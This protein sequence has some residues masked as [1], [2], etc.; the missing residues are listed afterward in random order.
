VNKPAIDLSDMIDL[1]HERGLSIG[2][3]ERSRLGRLL[4]N[5][6]YYR[7]SGYWRYF[8]AAPHLGD[9]RFDA[10]TT[11]DDV[12]RVYEFDRDLRAILQRGL[13]TF[14]VTLRARFVHFL[15][16][17]GYA[18]DY[19]RA[20]HYLDI[21]DPIGSLMSR[22]VEDQIAQ[23]LGRT[24]EPFIAS[25]RD[26]NKDIPVW[27]ACE[28]LSLG[29]ISKMYRLLQ[30]DDVRY[31]VSKS[32]NFPDPSFA[33]STFHSFSVLRNICAHQG[34]IWNRPVTIAN[35]VLK[36]LKTAP[37]KSVYQ[38][39]PWAWLTMLTHIVDLAGRNDHFSAELWQYIDAH[40]YAIEGLQYPHLR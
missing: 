31:G 1:L 16:M 38:R 5:N 35:P 20:S 17:N 21:R 26:R 37:D 32:F 6:G 34:R 24:K 18:Y 14:E 10:E 9:D 33:A 19:R 22:E 4:L 25:H 23:E 7:L 11:L 12:I 27:A 40:P 36:M 15:A 3:G 29:C 2:E 39:T 30:D 13:N 8:Q 28:V